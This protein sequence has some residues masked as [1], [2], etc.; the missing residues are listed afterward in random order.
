MIF[1]AS[2]GCFWP[3]TASM[4]SEVKKNHAHVYPYRNLRSFSEINLSIGPMVWPWIALSVHQDILGLLIRY[5]QASRKNYS[6]STYRILQILPATF[7]E[8][9]SHRKWHFRPHD[10]PVWIW[11]SK[12]M[13]IEI[14]QEGL[15]L[16]I[17]YLS[18]IVSLSA[19]ERGNQI[20]IWTKNSKYFWPNI[21]EST[22]VLPNWLPNHCLI[23]AWPLLDDSLTPICCLSNHWNWIA[24]F[25]LH[26]DWK[27][28]SRYQN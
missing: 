25:W 8:W 11:N 23:I 18:K 9:K 28:Y 7:F 14:T 3:L 13:K 24:D 20:H 21:W 5:K 19:Y 12:I 10:C 22:I 1:L 16:I 17:F 26:N 4:T 15:K 27:L 6:S 2:E